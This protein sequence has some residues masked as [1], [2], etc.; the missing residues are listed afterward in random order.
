M[1]LRRSLTTVLVCAH[2]LFAT[3]AASASSNPPSNRLSPLPP[4]RWRTNSAAH[5]PM[6]SARAASAIAELLAGRDH[7]HL[8]LQ[9]TAPTTQAVR[10]AA[11]AA[12]I[13]LLAYLGDNAFFAVS[14]T[15]STFPRSSTF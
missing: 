14:S 9:F 10:D 12:G 3:T 7:R 6:T 15:S 8:V 11:A 1:L 13:S 2:C 5:A 4:I